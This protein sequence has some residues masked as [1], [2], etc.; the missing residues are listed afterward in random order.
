MPK[1][2]RTIP[3]K[4]AFRQLVDQMERALLD[5]A[6]RRSQ[7]GILRLAEECVYRAYLLGLRHAAPDPDTREAYG[8]VNVPKITRY[9]M[10]TW[11]RQDAGEHEE[12]RKKAT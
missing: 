4:K 8:T 6:P 3:T 7:P 11:K 10:D 2:D 1:H 9:V 12:A 5:H